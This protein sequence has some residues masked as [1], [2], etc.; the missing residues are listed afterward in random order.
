MRSVAQRQSRAQWT[1]LLLSCGTVICAMQQAFGTSGLREMPGSV[2]STFSIVLFACL[3]I[4]C[5]HLMCGHGL[6]NQL[7]THL[8]CETV[9]ANCYSLLMCPA[10]SS[11]CMQSAS[12]MVLAADTHLGMFK[13]VC[14]RKHD[15][16]RKVSSRDRFA[17]HD[18]H[19][20]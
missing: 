3:L 19:K 16:S 14:T 20:T 1:V 15:T 6:P 17:L 5:Q 13:L 10:H 12:L 9:S 18:I 4:V 7:R 2:S 8:Y 11:L